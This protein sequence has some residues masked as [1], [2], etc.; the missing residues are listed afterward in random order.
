M[1]TPRAP[2]FSVPILLLAAACGEGP[3]SPS[4]GLPPALSADSEPTAPVLPSAPSVAPEDARSLLDT[5]SVQ[6]RF[7]REVDQVDDAQLMATTMAAR[8]RARFVDGFPGLVEFIMLNTGSGWQEKFLL[9]L[10]T[11]PPTGPVPLLVVFHKFGSSHGDV[12]N[13]TFFA[14]TRARGWYGM[15]PLGA[16]QKHFGNTES[17]INT[18]AALNLVAHLFSIDRQ[19]VYGVGFSMGGGA[20][21]NY[22]A[23]HLDPRGI[24]FAAMVDHTGGVSLGHTWF[25]EPDD[26]D[27]DDD[28]PMAGNNLEVPDILESY[29][30]GTPAASP[31][32]YQRCSLIDLD[33]IFGT[34]GPTTNFARNLKSIPTHIWIADA[35]PMAYLVTQTTAFDGHLQAQG[36]GHQFTSPAGNTHVWPTVDEFAACEW[37][38]TKSLQMPT[39]QST[40]TDENGRWYHFDIEQQAAGAFTPFTWDVNA[41]ARRVTISGTRNLQ[42]ISIDAASAG[43]ALSGNVTLRVSTADG[44]GD[45]VRLLNVSAAPLGVTRDGLAASGTF[46]ALTQTFEIVESSPTL[47][48]WVITFL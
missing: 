25:Y 37:L 18:R 36:V 7:G 39:S 17:Q 44:T 19:R 29:F 10:P 24:R 34:I 1:R 22:A 35:D 26:A 3:V 47:H 43:F 21:A 6:E 14:E 9:Q 5:L 46:D 42:R 38:Q 16:R 8:Y 11:N 41:A 2:F 31:F 20:M 28:T 27:L 48:E 32:E 40:L 45:R 4:T 13:T 23:R 12:L 33:P 15:A 30:G